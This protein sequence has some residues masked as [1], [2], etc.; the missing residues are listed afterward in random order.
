MTNEK[1]Q[2]V[3]A[4]AAA[5]KEKIVGGPIVIGELVRFSGARGRLEEARKGRE[6]SGESYLSLGGEDEWKAF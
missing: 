2:F 1:L 6:R 4:E 5:N 3:A